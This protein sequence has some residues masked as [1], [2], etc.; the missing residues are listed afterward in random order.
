MDTRKIKHEFAM[1]FCSL[2]AFV[3]L[4]AIADQWTDTHG[5]I[6]SYTAG[7]DSITISGCSFATNVVTIPDRISEKPVRTIS[8]NAFKGN[9]TIKELTIPDSITSLGQGV[10]S[11]CTALETITIGDG[12]MALPTV[13]YHGP[14]QMIFSGAEG[15]VDYWNNTGIEYLYD[16]A[17]FYNCTSLK[18]VNFGRNLQTIGNLA[19]LDCKSLKEVTL[20]ES[21]NTIGFHAFYR[22]SS[23][24]KVTVKGNV[25]SIGKRAFGAC[26]T[27]LYVDFQ[28]QSMTTAPG[29]GLFDF[30][31]ERLIVY[32]AEGSTGWTGVAGAAGLP[33]GGTWCG[34]AIAYGPPAE[35]PTYTVTFDPHGG[36][37]SE[38]SRIGYD[39]APGGELPIPV[40]PD[41]GWVFAGWYS[42]KFGGTKIT[43]SEVVTNDVTFCAHWTG[44]GTYDDGKG[45]SFGYVFE[46]NKIYVKS[47]SG[48]H[49]DIVLPSS[50]YGVAVQGIAAWAFEA[51]SQL[52]G[53]TIPDTITKIGDGA[54]AGCTALEYV[55][56]GTNVCEIG[57]KAF[58]ACR[59]LKAVELPNSVTNLSKHM[60]F[61]NCSAL[62]RVKLGAGLISLEWSA[63]DCVSGAYIGGRLHDL[64]PVYQSPFW[65]CPALETVELGERTLTLGA[66][67]FFNSANLKY[68]E[69][70]CLALTTTSTFR[71]SSKSVSAMCCGGSIQM[72]CHR[73]N[74]QD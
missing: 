49:G 34:R 16:K 27:L 4:C 35:V 26:P 29:A 58:Y 70:N 61:G 50:I 52:T 1:L 45:V 10:F 71:V 23:L 72:V 12:V 3:P 20:P 22:C 51:C 31:R 40:A 56:F 55:N 25:L 17:I 47:A 2:S 5:N 11:G 74:G 28:G 43:A 64:T 62:R 53:V 39:D 8:E 13:K 68:A 67:A 41:D 21:V 69:D 63:T 30:D 42:S 44:N 60:S 59:A 14:N 33:E 37:V 15:Y 9:K 24:L 6:W 36:S 7:A 57:G 46:G 32:A 54:F 66:D 38:S 65:D 19:F 18:T 48:I 73:R